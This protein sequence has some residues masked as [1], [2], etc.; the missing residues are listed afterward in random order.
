MEDTDPEDYGD[1]VQIAQRRKQH[2]PEEEK[3]R[4]ID[5]ADWLVAMEKEAV[6]SDPKLKQQF[7]ADLDLW[8][9][10]WLETAINLVKSGKATRNWAWRIQFHDGDEDLFPRYIL[11]YSVFQMAAELFL[12][13]MWLLQFP[14]LRPFQSWVYV[15][16]AERV[17]FETKLKRLSHD[18]VKLTEAVEAIPQYSADSEVL[19][20]LRII[21]GVFK[22][23]YYPL[24]GDGVHWASA[25]YPRK[26][27][28]DEMG[29]GVPDNWKEYPYQWML[30]RLFKTAENRVMELWFPGNQ[31]E[32]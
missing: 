24:Y 22:R 26:F 10:A 30:V 2:R 31:R 27:Y 11:E 1:D 32:L 23:Y 6:R 19:R 15:A 21:R 8:P 17:N 9:D 3:R 12:K 20:F 29:R 25:R 4:A 7:V 14:E 5:Y 18:I 28:E 16:P 13:G